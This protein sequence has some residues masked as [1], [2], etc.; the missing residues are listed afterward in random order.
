MLLTAPGM[1]SHIMNYYRQKSPSDDGKAAQ[2]GR[3]DRMGTLRLISETE[4]LPFLGFLE[5]GK[6]VRMFE[7]ELYMAPIVSH[8]SPSNLFLLVRDRH[9]PSRFFIRP[10]PLQL[11]VGQVQPLSSVYG[12]RERKTP[13]IMKDRLHAFILRLCMKK[14]TNG[15]VSFSSIASAFPRCKYSHIR[16]IL[17]SI[18]HPFD[19]DFWKV[20]PTHSLPSEEELRSL[21]TP[22]MI[23]LYEAMLVGMQRLHDMGVKRLLT[24]KEVRQHI[25]P[26][27]LSADIALQKEVRELEDVLLTSPWALSKNF[28]QIFFNQ[29]TIRLAVTPEAGEGAHNAFGDDKTL[30]SFVRR[31]TPKEQRLARNASASVMGTAADL[32]RLTEEQAKSY[33]IQNGYRD[34]DLRHVKRWD[35]VK[36]VRNISSSLAASHGRDAH[37]ARFAREAY[38]D[39]TRSRLQYTKDIRDV[40]GN[41]LRFLS[42]TH[43]D[44]SSSEEDEEG[45]SGDASAD[46][47]M[48]L[49]RFLVHQQHN[50]SDTLMSSAE[51]LR[52]SRNEREKILKEERDREMEQQAKATVRELAHCRPGRRPLLRCTWTIKYVT[53]FT[54]TYD[55]D[56]R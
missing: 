3:V 52:L 6:S 38:L 23:C 53:P 4:E 21:L 17:R 16:K 14:D 37:L 22:K 39:K 28:T 10:S 9:S 2:K 15:V 31:H 51:F 47:A 50:T 5:K 45:E 36:Y 44:S 32:R 55:R 27:I 11:S 26:H 12:P 43:E 29:K 25:P 56:T 33:L 19:G 7:N 42:S 48:E 41:Q 40:F 20:S 24:V 54:S 34:E 46:H 18:A 30:F 1:V 35:L 13:L 8:P 49:E